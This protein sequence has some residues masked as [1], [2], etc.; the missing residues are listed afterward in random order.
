MRHRISLVISIYFLFCRTD[1]AHG[2]IVYMVDYGRAEK[3]IMRKS[4]RHAT[5]N[6]KKKKKKEKKTAQ[7]DRTGEGT[8]YTAKLGHPKWS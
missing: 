1:G 6:Q 2:L 8:S 3:Y 5:H 4:K 7:G